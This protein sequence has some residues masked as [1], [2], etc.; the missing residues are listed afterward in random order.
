MK[1]ESG[2]NS[3]WSQPSKN[4]SENAEMVAMLAPVQRD[5]RVAEEESLQGS[6]SDLDFSNMTRRELF[7]WMNNQ[8]R[9]GQMT[10]DES[11]PFLAMSLKIKPSGEPV[12][13]DTD[14]VR[15]DFIDIA[16]QRFDAAEARGEF[17]VADRWR[18]AWNSLQQLQGTLP[19]LNF[20]A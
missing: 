12:D 10:V 4:R 2:S 15:M 16:K 1:I 14:P 11:T 20:F 18:I 19:S 17:E 13:M 6:S 8:I 5:S 3:Y 9:S 7:D